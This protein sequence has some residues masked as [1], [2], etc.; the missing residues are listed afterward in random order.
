M[1]IRN[2]D[3]L[4]KPQSV[5]LIGA[6]R[7]ERSI[8]ATLLNNMRQGGY[9]GAIWPVNPKYEELAGLPCY[10]RVAALPEAPELAVIC[11]P[12]A[13][14]PALIREL[15]ARGTKAAIVMTAGLDVLK[16]GGGKTVHQAMLDA[17]RPH[18]LRILGPNSVG[19][20]V[21]ALGLNASFA[22]TGAQPGK[23]AFVSQSGALVTGVLDWAKANGI[24]FSKFVSLGGAGD[25]DFGDLL[26]YLAGDADTGAI[27]LY[28]QDLRAARKFM[29]AA[30]VAA[31]SKPVIVL[32]AGREAE[33]AAAAA[34]HSGALAGS[35]GVY[36]A[37][38]RR[39]GMLRVDSSEELFNAAETLAHAKPQRGG[40]LAIVTNGGGLGVMATDALVGAGGRLAELSEATRQQ[41]GRVLPPA[42]PQANPVDIG[43]DAPLQRYLAALPPLLEAPEADALLF[44]HAPSAMVSSAE[45][46]EALAPLARAAPRNVLSCWLGGAEVAPARQILSRAGLPS[47]AT[48]E[49]AVLAFMQ[50]VQ[51]RRN[52]DLLMEVPAQLPAAAAPQRA[53]V[54]A[55]VAAAL[56]AGQDELGQCESQQVLAAYG[57]PVADTRMARDV[58]HALA[59][60]G[61]IGY[62]VALKIHA[63]AL[64]HKSDVGGVALDLETPEALR[65]AAAAMLKRV[66]RLRPDAALQGFAVQRMARR[67]QAQELIVGVSSDPVFGPVVLV[68]Q[69]GVAVEVTADR[70]IGLPPLNMALARDMLGRTRVAKLLAGYRNL[71]AADLDAICHTLIQVAELAAD[72]AELAELDINPLLADAGGVIALDARIRLQPGARTDRLAIRPYPQELEQQRQWQGGTLTLRPIRPEDAPAHLAFF[73]ALDPD[74][75]R[76]RFFTAVR[77]LAPAQLARLTQIDYDRAMAFIATRGGADGRPETLGVVRAV[78]DPDNIDAD[79][80]IIVRSD[81]KGQGLGAI[82]FGKLIE[83]FRSRGTEQLSGDALSQNTGVQHLVRSFGGTVHASPDP[84]T[85]RLRLKLQAPAAPPS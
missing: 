7:K 49:R 27:L 79:F 76:L 68:G 39:A 23:I 36:D 58:E 66:R 81:L 6:S 55:I 61:E 15:G 62:P 50:I 35:D 47:Y 54:R 59:L 75:V 70:A 38:I 40:R 78:A 46:A 43:G 9:A 16:A 21:P 74:D 64:P 48:P 2:F 56:A 8:G 77:E 44:L 73:N 31:R 18:L 10:G 29:S 52:Q 11:T 45:L 32:K 65:A 30:R 13:T 12:P 69:G 26:D 19:L 37:A 28:M 20:L 41:L 72:V 84:G 33:G 5:A 3:S 22:H 82:L 85:V 42:W 63:P 83:Y 80:A 24:G 34:S 25:V 14:I 60:A 1:S 67:P 53:R 71:P 51:Y 17:A 4:F 57:I